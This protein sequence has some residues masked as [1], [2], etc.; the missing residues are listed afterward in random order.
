[1]K[2]TRINLEQ[3]AEHANLTLALHKAARGKRHR[4]Q[5]HRFLQQAEKSLNQLACD[6]LAGEMPYGDFRTF[7]IHDPKRRIIH[8]ACFEDRIFHHAVMNLAGPVLE[9][10]MLPTSFACRPAL[11]VHRAA[12][13]VQRHIRRFNWFGKIDIDSYFACIEH[14]VLLSLL[15]RRFKGAAFQAQLGR[16][17]ACYQTQ[18]GKG[19]PI[20]SL[21]SQYFANYYLDGLDRLLNK[22]PEVGGHVRYMDDIVWWCDD[23]QQVKAVLHQ[24]QNWLYVHR[25]LSVKP[26]WQIQRSKQGIHFC[27]YRILPGVMRMSAR[28]KRRYQSR[29][30]YWEKQYRQGSIT[31]TQLQTAYAA[32]HAITQGTDS[33]G[34]RRMNLLQHPALVV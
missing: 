6:I 24:V 15:L 9:R 23:R 4:D 18:P 11:G 12:D 14:E 28:C 3:I 30:L 33:L 22:L 8:A 13:T 26:T 2:R 5:V 34:W 10:A 16:L 25:Q 7:I 20:G 27:G 19:L 1:M 29:R 21:T 17:L 31:S 32:V